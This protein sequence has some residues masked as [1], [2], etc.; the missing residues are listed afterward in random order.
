MKKRIFLGFGLPFFIFLL[1]SLIAVLYI[2]ETTHRMDKLF[3]LHRV[4]ILREDLII[5]VQQV[6]SH[7]SRSKVR[8]G[9]D[10][11]VL[12]ASMREME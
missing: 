1:G 10:V 4:E 6:Q 12:M 2:T 9:P 7:V 3:L 11:D 8:G 5:H